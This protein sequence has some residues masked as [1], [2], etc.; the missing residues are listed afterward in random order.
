MPKKNGVEIK[1]LDKLEKELGKLQKR[2]EKLDGEHQVKLEDLFPPEFMRAH[3]QHPTMEAMF[4]AS[5]FNPQ[6]QEDLEAI[7]QA[8][9]DTFVAETTDFNSWDEMMGRA[10]EEYF[11][12]QFFG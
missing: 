2:A 3:T 11:S 9:L 1:G 8:E 5:A 7:P 12:K 10:A 4:E 6:S